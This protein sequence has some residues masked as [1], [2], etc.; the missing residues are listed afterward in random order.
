MVI[1][2]M[3]THNLSLSNCGDTRHMYYTRHQRLWR[4]VKSARHGQFQ[5]NEKTP[6]M[7]NCNI[8]FRRDVFDRQFYIVLAVEE[9][10]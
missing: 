10:E 4:L 5:D 9:N 8:W 6:T 7:L 2:K 1:T 3:C